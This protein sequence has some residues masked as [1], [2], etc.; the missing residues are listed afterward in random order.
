M[1]LNS[2]LLM[3]SISGCAADSVDSLSLVTYAPSGIRDPRTPNRSIHSKKRSMSIAPLALSQIRR[4]NMCAAVG[5]A[6]NCAM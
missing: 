1:A 4:A 6:Y 2:A 3:V 5:S